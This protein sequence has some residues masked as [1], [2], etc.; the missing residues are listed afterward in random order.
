[1]ALQF[2]PKQET[3]TIDWL[4]GCKLKLK[5]PSPAQRHR[6]Y[7]DVEDGESEEKGLE[8]SDRYFSS[9][10]VGWEGIESKPGQALEF[11]PEN[12]MAVYDELDSNLTDAGK[13][14]REKFFTFA[15]G[16]SGKN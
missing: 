1:M 2:R 13:V 4:D 12:R 7:S 16:M 3:A 5:R 11:T 6:I 10:I 9:F 14:A 15:M 8:R